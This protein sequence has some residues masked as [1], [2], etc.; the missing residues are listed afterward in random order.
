MA[1]PSEEDLKALKHLS[2]LDIDKNL[3]LFNSLRNHMVD[4]AK[5]LIA[6]SM[7]NDSKYLFW[8]KDLQPVSLGYKN[9]HKSPPKAV[10]N[11][12][13]DNIKYD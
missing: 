11:M 5:V 7:Y 9:S 6:A 10:Q 2:D 3:N 12:L 4:R 8:Q 1:N 13:Y